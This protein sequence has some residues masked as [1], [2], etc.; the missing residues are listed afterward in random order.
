MLDWTI[1]ELATFDLPAMVEWVC[2]TTG[3]DKASFPTGSRATSSFCPP[4]RLHRSFTRQWHRF[5]YLIAWCPPGHRRETLCIHCTCA[6][7]LCWSTNAR[8]PLYWSRKDG[9][10]NVEAFLWYPSPKPTFDPSLM[11]L[12]GVL[13]FIPLMRYSYDYVPALIFGTMGYTMF[14]FLFDW[15]DRNW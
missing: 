15:T 5:H 12:Q 8:F 7:S 10:E 2:K 9:M 6:C 11:L 4:D 3:Y 1:N 13:D 14:S